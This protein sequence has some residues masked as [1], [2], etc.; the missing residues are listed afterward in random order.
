MVIAQAMAAGKPVIATRV[1]GVPDMVSDGVTGLLCDPG[2]SEQLAECLL[3]LLRNRS[4][5]LQM[6]EQ[7][8]PLAVNR[9]RADSVARSTM[10]AYLQILGRC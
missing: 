10:E 9:Y 7:A 8:R 2:N 3:R 6:G 5:C 1:G 4:L